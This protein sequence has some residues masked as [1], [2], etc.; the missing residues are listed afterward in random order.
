[1][2]PF[3]PAEASAAVLMNERRAQSQKG[4]EEEEDPPPARSQEA[5]AMKGMRLLLVER[6]KVKKKGRR[7]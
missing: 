4:K 1:M 6:E 5:V 3:L 7:M 2:W